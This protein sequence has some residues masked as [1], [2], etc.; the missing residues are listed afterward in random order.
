MYVCVVSG[1]WREPGLP[2]SMPLY[3]T[4][5]RKSNDYSKS[6]DKLYDTRNRRPTKIRSIL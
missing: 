6:N 2:L 4:P 3:D 5:T 1:A